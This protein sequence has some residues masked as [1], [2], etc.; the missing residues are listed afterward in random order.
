MI[1]RLGR[2]EFFATLP[3][4]FFLLLALV[5]AA[6]PVVD[7]DGRS[8]S[9]WAV[10]HRIAVDEVEGHASLILLILFAT[11]LLGSLV[12]SL[13]VSIVDRLTPPFRR[14][15]PPIDVVREALA[16]L[17]QHKKATRFTAA[18]APKV[19][20][21]LPTTVFNHWKN[22]LCVLNQDA[23]RYYQSFESRSRMFAGMAM[24]GAVGCVCALVILY[25]AGWSVP[26]IG[27]ELLVASGALVLLFGGQ[28]RRVRKQEAG[29]LV[30]LF[31]CVRSAQVEG[32]RS[33]GGDEADSEPEEK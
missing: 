8:W 2:V 27:V 25:R 11:Y 23:F 3:A 15:F 9:A 13:P 7:P 21:T 20:S 12:R 31:V 6:S 4:G 5:L 22:W 28:F 33:P 30:S 14:G 10:I 18:H 17:S 16:E 26:R 19:G 32:G 24:A 1:E 29:V